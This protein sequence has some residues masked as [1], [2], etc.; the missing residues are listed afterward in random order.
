MIFDDWYY[1]YIKFSILTSK[2]PGI[3][4]TCLLISFTFTVT[5]FVTCN[6]YLWL[7]IDNTNYTLSK[8]F[9][10]FPFSAHDS[11]K[12]FKDHI[13]S[14]SSLVGWRDVI[15]VPRGNLNFRGS[16]RVH[17]WHVTESVMRSSV[18]ST[19]RVSIHIVRPLIV[20]CYKVLHVLVRYRIQVG[21]HTP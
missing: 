16:N 21:H 14:D 13:T 4:S 3:P 18:Y 11:L 15:C 17:V 1:G 20:S 9:D 7:S 19:E 6:Y 2:F 10:Q 8:C 12:S 5:V